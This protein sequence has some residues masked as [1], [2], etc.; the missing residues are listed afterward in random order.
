M[1]ATSGHSYVLDDKDWALAGT[2]VA[3]LA[4]FAGWFHFL[5]RGELGPLSEMVLRLTEASTRSPSWTPSVG[6][7]D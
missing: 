3:L 1:A 4:A 5:W 2:V 7:S 6:A